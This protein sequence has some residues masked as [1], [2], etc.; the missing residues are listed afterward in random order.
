VEWKPGKCDVILLFMIIRL[1]IVIRIAALMSI[2]G[3]PDL[4]DCLG[5]NLWKASDAAAQ[6][7]IQASESPFDKLEL[8]GLFAAGPPDVYASQ[9]IRE[10]GTDFTPDPTFIASFPAPEYRAIL[11]AINPRAAKPMSPNRDEAYEL[12]RKAL[13]AQRNGQFALANQS[14]QQALRLAPDS[15]TLHLAWA[16]DLLLFQKHP[17]AEVQARQ[18]LKLWPENAEA[19]TALALSLTAQKQFAEAESESREALRIFPK[20]KMAMFALGVALTHEQKYGDAIPFLRASIPVLPDVPELNKLLGI[21]LTETRKITEGIDQL[22][23][24]VKLAPEDAE[25]HYYLGVALRLKGDSEGAHTHFAEALRLQS[26][27]SQYEAAA[28]SHGTQTGADVEPGIKPE[29]GAVSGNIYTNKFFGFTYQ[30]PKGWTVLSADAAR[31]TVEIGGAVMSTGNPTEQDIKKAAE[32]LAHPLLYITEGRVSTQPVSLKTVMVSA[33]DLRSTPGM[34]AES[35]MKFMAQ[36][37]AQPGMPMELRG[38]PEER[39]IGGRTFW[40]ESFVIRVATGTSY[41]S[42]FVSEDKRY[43]LIFNLGSPDLGSLGDLEKSLTS[44]HFLESSN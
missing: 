12:L 41:G 4:Q 33:F 19:H 26:N 1:L 30:F 40:K 24:Y 29:D 21:C 9:V 2:L 6:T 5:Q 10:R 31:A 35:Y 43:L 22:S 15:A 16:N 32:R 39:S 11:T 42:Q 25:G 17:A 23:L 8:F 14:Y 34:T 36:R 7:A 38:S 3:I 18:S 44:I 37:F 27:N 20:Q 28:R 13:N